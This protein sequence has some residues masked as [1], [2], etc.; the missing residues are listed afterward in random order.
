MIHAAIINI[1]IF[2]SIG[3]KASTHA[4]RNIP[5][6]AYLIL[7]LQP[8]TQ[9]SATFLQL[10]EDACTEALFE[11]FQWRK[12]KRNIEEIFQMNKKLL[13]VAV[14]GALAAPGLAM[15][16]AANVSIYGLMDIRVDNMKLSSG[17]GTSLNSQTKSH[18][19]GGQPNYV[20][21]R[22]SEDLG[23]GLSAFF[24]VETQLFPDARQDTG[25]QQATNASLGGRPTFLGLR[26]TGWG[27]LSAGYQDAIYKDVQRATWS[28]APGTTHAG[29][30][31]GNGNTSGSNPSTQ[32]VP[33]Q[34]S[35]TN[36]TASDGS[37]I[38]TAAPGN[39]TS[40]NR[41]ISKSVNYR[42]PTLNGFRGAMQLTVNEFK[43]GS[44]N[45]GANPTVALANP[46]LQG[47]QNPTLVA[48][49]LAWTGG[50][51]S[52]AAAYEVHRGFRSL[53][54]ASTQ[55][56]TTAGAAAVVAAGDGNAKDTGFTIGGQWNYGMG[57]IGI[58][59][60]RIKYAATL[61]TPT[62][63]TNDSYTLPAWALQGTYNLTGSDTLF[64]AYSK[65]PGR[66]S[67]G[68]FLSTAV[69]GTTANGNLGQN[70]GGDTGAKM[71]SFGVQ[72]DL[73]KRTAL[74]AYYSRIDN[75]ASA[76]Y[77]YPSDSR[78]TNNIGT[79]T[80]TTGA[81]AG[82]GIGVDSTSYNIGVKHTF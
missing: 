80:S 17:T 32:C 61:N 19:S 44:T 30:I 41:T 1:Y 71:L 81:S 79:V 6:V 46:G 23:S 20:G 55:T 3:C 60:E 11:P 14:A 27:E 45:V 69:V 38:C 7:C 33:L 4:I 68:T 54:V 50:P 49:S 74:Y 66:K 5:Y 67:C 29:I 9:A 78:A 12:N 59:Y 8:L 76:N 21:F 75:N 48:Y 64:G 42:T 24:Q 40:F 82:L 62:S 77:N 39:S 57:K 73:S 22:G 53:N 56:G 34:S 13:A 10:W 18:M 70:C 52:A 65:T 43:Q 26:S 36:A 47:S 37:T 28:V 51:F 58:G 72:H 15:A 2:I 16:Q 63:A 25:A 31:M 35:G